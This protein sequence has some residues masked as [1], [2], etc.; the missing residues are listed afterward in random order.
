MGVDDHLQR[1][2]AKARS[3]PSP[4]P[5]PEPSFDDRIF[6]GAAP[7]AAAISSPVSVAPARKSGDA[8]MVEFR[9]EIRKL[10][11][12]INDLLAVF[13]KAHEDI[14]AE[15]A[16]ELAEKIDKLVE[17]NEEIARALLLLLE[18]HREHLPQISKHTRLS[19]ELRLRKPSRLA[20]QGP[21]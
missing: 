1:F 11:L 16:A 8:G 6:S 13:R 3:V 18:L 2:G 12:A 14:R 5:A 21:K 20:F 4:Q 17:Q 7:G 10:T 9:S 19:S 15:P